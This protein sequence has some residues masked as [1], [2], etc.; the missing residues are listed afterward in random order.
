MCLSEVKNGSFVYRDAFFVE[1]GQGKRHPRASIAELKELLLPRKN[2]AAAA[3]DEV[4]HWYEAQLV[5]YGLPQSKDKNTAKVRL[6]AALSS[7]SLL[8]P[9][10]VREIESDL[11]KEYAS[12]LRKAKAAASKDASTSTPPSAGRKRKIE[13]SE[14]NE[15][16]KSSKTKIVVKVGNVTIDIDHQDRVDGVVPSKKQRKTDSTT[17]SSKLSSKQKT[18]LSTSTPK[19]TPAKV[20]RIPVTKTNSITDLS[21]KHT[22]NGR[23][24]FGADATGV[25]Q[26]KCEPCRRKS[27]H[28][29][30]TSPGHRGPSS[31]SSISNDITHSRPKQTARRGGSFNSSVGQSHLPNANRPSQPS[32]YMDDPA[33]EPPPPYSRDWE[34]YSPNHSTSRDHRAVQISGNYDLVLSKYGATNLELRLSNDRDQMWGTFEIG[35]DR[36]KIGYLRADGLDDIASGTRKTLGWRTNDRE[37]GRLRFG[38]GCDGWIVFDGTGFVQ[39]SFHSIDYGKDV[40]FEGHL[41]HAFDDE[42]TEEREF[43]IEALSANWHEFPVRAYGD[44]R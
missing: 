4:G 5:H 23:S 27:E 33:D 29:F 41:E 42:T 10:N 11:K 37:T 2:R 35:E 24:C 34:A 14:T 16:V 38:K 12:L 36:E 13:A 3:R 26:W 6:T 31:P 22:V 19:K 25:N 15:L 8:V 7:S 44:R 39:G 17:S 1:V 30:M 32:T 9:D 40:E 21:V 20:T 43:Q 18:T 28:S